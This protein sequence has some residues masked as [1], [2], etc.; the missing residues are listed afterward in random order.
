MCKTI[1]KQVR[2]RL[3]YFEAKAK[4]KALLHIDIAG[5]IKIMYLFICYS[6]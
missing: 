6:S 5:E 2:I 4:C 3:Q 1:R